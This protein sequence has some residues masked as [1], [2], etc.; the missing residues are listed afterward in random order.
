MLTRSR[1]GPART[2]IVVVAGCGLTYWTWTLVGPIGLELGNRHGL[3]PGTWALIGV[4]PI[5]VGVLFRTPAGMLA[6][7][8]GARVVLPAV[9]LASAVAVLALAMAGSVAALVVVACAAGLAAGAVPAGAGAIVRA[10][11]PGRRGSAL[12]VLAAGLCLAAAAGIASR[13]L[14]DVD[15]RHGLFVLAGVEL[16]YALLA[17][18]LLHDR[19]DPAVRSTD[20]HPTAPTLF[21]IPA[22]RHL[23]VWYGVSCGGIVV[24]DLVLPSYLIRTYAVPEVRAELGTAAAVGL[25]AAA[26]LLGGWLCRRRSPTAVLRTCYAVVAVMLLLL[27]F[28][29]PLAWAAAPALAG[30]AIGVGTAFGT[31]LALIGRTAPPAH[32][33]AVAGVISA[34]GSAVT[35]L[36]ALLVTAVHGIEGSYTIAVMLLAGGAVASAGNLHARRT[37]LSAA[38]AFPAP[39]AGASEAATTVVSLSAR[40][41]RAHLGDVTVALAALATRHELVIVYAGRDPAPG[42]C[43]G[44]SLVAGLRRHL[45][46]HTVLAITAGTPPHPHETAAVADLLET[47]AVPV[48]L[49]TG[50]DPAPT[51]RLLA[52][53]VHADQVVHLAPDRVEGLIPHARRPAGPA[54]SRP[55]LR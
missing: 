19:P 21:R 7:R 22:T 8:F 3:D 40:E 14:P 11:P 15:R 1:G 31:V 48:V 47:G 43:H 13:V 38:V 28:Q 16:G 17:A 20:G 49:V 45:P 10:F 44:Y 29:P 12:S 4:V 36:P 42:T 35:I 5:L 54:P 30:A 34:P 41:V 24:F 6:D 2:L 9:S 55:L 52:D 25:A 50:G 33:G 39:A 26:C 46:A 23:A 32:A 53:G 37:W 18:V 27:A 51:A